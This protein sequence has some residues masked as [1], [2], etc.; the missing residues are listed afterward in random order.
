MYS[1]ETQKQLL[2]DFCNYRP[3]SSFHQFPYNQ[4]HGGTSSI[5]EEN[6]DQKNVKNAPKRSSKGKA[7]MKSE[8]FFKNVFYLR[9]KNN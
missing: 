8:F 4:S 5:F 3:E 2:N 7:I 1:T 6:S 9:V